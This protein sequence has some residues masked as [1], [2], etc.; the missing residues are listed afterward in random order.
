MTEILL[1]GTFHFMESN[2]DFY[3]SDS[4]NQLQIITNKLARFNPD[5][6]AIECAVHA[7]K[8]IDDSFK[9]FRLSDLANYEKMKNETLGTVKLYGQIYPITYNNES[10]QIGYRLGK[11]LH[12]EK[13]YC[14]DDDTVLD[15]SVIENAT[16]SLKTKIDYFSKDM[17]KHKND[18]IQ[19]LYEYYNSQE[20][21]IK[22]HRIYLEAN[23]INTNNTYNGSMFVTK[24]YERNLKIFSNIQNL[25]TDC[26]R[27]FIIYGAGHLQILRDLINDSDD[28]I[29]ID[30]KNYL[31][32]DI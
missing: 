29:L 22:N 4:Q 30:N 6:I 31:S 14:I 5:K 7:Q 23:S 24:W 10:I 18:T 17:E 20:W 8:S 16:G 1:L 9:K 11:M 28:L 27:L 19:K 32:W 3:T 12:L 15:M 21:S 13:I 26:K 25:C 2:I